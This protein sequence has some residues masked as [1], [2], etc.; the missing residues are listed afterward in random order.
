MSFCAQ[1][2]AYNS[3]IALWSHF[4]HTHYRADG[5]LQ[6]MEV[7]VDEAL[8]AGEVLRTANEY[9]V[10]WENHSDG[11]K[12]RPSTMAKLRQV[13]K[14]EFSWKTVLGWKLS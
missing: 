5:D 12:H 3:V 1:I 6:F 2:T 10:Y 4:V 11:G 14:E 8:L 7:P 9:L 13:A